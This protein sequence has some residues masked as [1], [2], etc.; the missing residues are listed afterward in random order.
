MIIKDGGSSVDIRRR[1]AETK[2]KTSTST[3]LN[4]WKDRNIT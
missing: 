2:T 4:I 3:L 1:L